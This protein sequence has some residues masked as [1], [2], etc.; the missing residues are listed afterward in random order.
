MIF[1]ARRKFF[2]RRLCLRLKRRGKRRTPLHRWRVGDRCR[3]RPI[4]PYSALVNGS[5]WALTACS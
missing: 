4:T 3:R 2:A 1:V 5:E